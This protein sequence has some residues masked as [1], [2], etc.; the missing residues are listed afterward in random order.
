MD[1]NINVELLPIKKRRL[2]QLEE[3]EGQENERGE[4]MQQQDLM[5]KSS[6]SSSSTSTKNATAISDTNTTSST[7]STSQVYSG[8]QSSSSNAIDNFSKD[9]FPLVKTKVQQQVPRRAGKS[10]NASNVK[11]ITFIDHDSQA[12][13]NRAHMA[14]AFHPKRYNRNQN[15]NS[16]PEQTS[17]QSTSS[18]RNRFEEEDV[19]NLDDARLVYFF[20]DFVYTRHTHTDLSDIIFL[21]QIT[22]ISIMDPVFLP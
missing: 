22:S 4:Q 10:Y 19:Y 17:R 2:R 6:I 20:L 9:S 15:Q 16:V 13:W 14:Y 5:H 11:G 12:W 8:Q 7:L 3:N 21:N 1:V 18:S